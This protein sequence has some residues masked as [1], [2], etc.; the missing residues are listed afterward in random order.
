MPSLT[1]TFFGVPQ[2][3]VDGHKVDI[4]RKKALALLAYLA[5]TRR[6]HSR[7]ALATM[8]WPEADQKRARATLRNVIWAVN[9]TPAAPWLVVEGDAV[10]LHSPGSPRPDSYTLDLDVERFRS[11]VDA[12]VAHDHKPEERCSHCVELLTEAV[13][14]AEGEFLAGFSLP[15]APEF[16]EWQF[17]EASSLRQLQATALELL[18]AR[19][20]AAGKAGEAVAYGRRLVALDPLHEPA[21]RTLMRLYAAAGQQQAALRQYEVVRGKLDQE[22]GVMPAAETTA[23]HEAL[24]SGRQTSVS[25]GPGEQATGIG[26]PDDIGKHSQVGVPH[27]LPPEATPL[28]GRELELS[29]LAAMLGERAAKL[30]TL[31]GPGGIGKTRLAVAA[32]ARQ[33]DRKEFSDGVFFVSLAP[34]ADPANLLAAI[35]ESVGYPLHSEKRTGEQQ[36]VDFLSDKSM[37]LV[38]DNFEHLLTDGPNSAVALVEAVL[39]RASG[40]AMLVTS[41]ER[42]QLYQE[43]QYPLEGLA[44]A[45]RVA[46]ESGS[47]YA[48][49]EL[50]L[51][52]VRRRQP[53]YS[54]AADDWPVLDEICRLVEGMPLALELA[55]TWLDTLSLMEIVAEISNN[56]TFL[57]TDLRNVPD[58]HRSMQAVFETSWGALEPSEQ[59][60]LSR[61]SVFRGGFTGDAARAVAGASPVVLRR[62]VSK[63]LLRFRPET[64]RYDLHELLRQFA[65]DKLSGQID[66]ARN[67]HARYYTTLLRQQEAA[68][69]GGQQGEALATIRRESQNSRA[70][71]LW[72]AEQREHTWVAESLFSLVL[73]LESHGQLEEGATL[74]RRAAEA[75]AQPLL[76]ANGVLLSDKVTG[77]Q[78]PLAET[79]VAVLT[80]QARFLLLLYQKEAARDVLQRARSLHKAFAL[81]QHGGPATT[82]RL[83]MTRSNLATNDNFA[84]ESVRLGEKALAAYQSAGDEWG[85]AMVVDRL[86][87]IYMNQGQHDRAITMLKES[88]AIRER[89][90]D[91]RGVARTYNIL[92]LAVLHVGEISRSE[93]YLRRS[94]ELFRTLGN[95]ADLSNPLAVLGINL[96]FGGKFAECLT[97]Y[98]ECWAIHRRLNLP[99]EPFLASVTIMRARIELGLYDEAAALASDSLSRYRRANDAWSI[100][101]ALHCLGR[102]DLVRGDTKRA[103][104]QLEE[105]VSL[106]QKMN[107]R[108]LLPEVLFCLGL[109]YRAAGEREQALDCLTEGLGIIL[110]TA[111]LSPMRFELPLVALLKADDGQVKQAVELFAAARQVGYAANS[112]WFDDVAW[113]HIVQHERSLPAAA[114][115]AA[116]ERGRARDLLAT[117]RAML[118]E[119]SQDSPQWRGRPATESNENG[120]KC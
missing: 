28:I 108:S 68:L 58:R 56:L 104:S 53:D 26:R 103:A 40:V 10:G 5:V 41:R 18:I 109:A 48:A 77:D 50:F 72:A 52:S 64:Q 12:A 17:F 45:D 102:V 80:D 57:A 116:E 59:A 71:F 14:L 33:V 119:L 60:T 49:A 97:R 32:A 24:R 90:Q 2:L 79:V 9:Q 92:G 70:A 115:A 19:L 29:Q 106:L 47:S 88:L 1:L 22:L 96:L 98:E 112:R 43:Q 54:P 65:A 61:L 84:G 114:A 25:G 76:D 7:D 51:Q 39:D 46:G 69:K 27:N 110:E 66:A 85:E 100:A 120:H 34:L 42:L 91:S 117:A 21:Q 63:S 89:L 8:L 20:G 44:V 15:D 74:M 62:L 36:L 107:E 83:A 75:L 31:V 113:Q 67:R 118:N 16:E 4:T 73:F 3:A 35:A 95:E 105:S 78:R 30:I 87:Q 94:L 6:P 13:G 38:L 37:L 11:L 93:W 111:P 23:L 99:H 55:A 101:F 82:A 81:A 86:S